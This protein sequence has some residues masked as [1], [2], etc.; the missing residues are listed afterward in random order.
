MAIKVKFITEG[1]DAVESG[2]KKVAGALGDVAKIAG[3]FVLAQG[4]MKAPAVL[5]DLASSSRDLE[6]QM[7]KASVVF[8]D[9]IGVVEDWADA[10][11]KS[12]GLT[13]RQA[14]NL[15]AGMAD[16]LVPMGM[17]REAAAKMSTETLNLSGAL[18]EWSGGQKSA[19][20]VAQILQSAY[21]GE[22]DGLKGLGIA[23]SA[24]D[25][26]ARLAAKGQDELTGAAQQQA[27]ALAI[28]E[29]IMEKSTDAQTAFANGA[30]SAARK[31]AEMNATVSQ[32]KEDLAMAMGPAVAFVTTK[33]AELVPVVIEGARVF[34]EEMQPKVMA[35]VDAAVPVLQAIGKV[36]A[37]E[38]AKFR[39]YYESDIKPALDNIIAGVSAVIA[40][41]VDH[42]PEIWRVVGP[43]MDMIQT[44]IETVVGVIRE[45]FQILIDLISGDFSGAWKNLQELIALIWNDI[46][47]IIS[48]TIEAVLELI[49]GLGPLMLEALGNMSELLVEA[50][51]DI[52]RGLIRGIGAMKDEALGAIG[53]VAS[54]VK[55]KAL[56]AFKINS[57]SKVFEDIGEGVVEGLV[58]G[59]DGK[60]ADAVR[61]VE[62][63]IKAAIAAGAVDEDA[64]SASGYWKMGTSTN[65][66]GAGVEWVD[67]SS[68]GANGAADALA[69]VGGGNGV[70]G[71]AG[72]GWAYV[73]NG[74]GGY[75]LMKFP[76]TDGQTYY[77]FDSTGAW[78]S[79]VFHTEK[80]AASTTP[81]SDGGAA[82]QDAPGTGKS[83]GV[84]N[85]GSAAQTKAAQEQAAREEEKRWRDKMLALQLELV[86]LVKQGQ[87]TPFGSG[88]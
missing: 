12:M 84:S 82:V 22:T 67:T 3:G 5:M 88:V 50:G 68:G 53:D 37:E 10:N 34:A 25:V 77:Y 16:L 69:T 27:Q 13:S 4:L 42:W 80:P 11:A 41:I 8:G 36:V 1:V 61:S 54:G 44:H 47:S 26:Q 35:F 20:E 2:A 60:A 56:G 63:M 17:S 43:I 32:A 23:I 73:A 85:Q 46:K 87:R 49:K 58:L 28:Q 65:G 75:K 40:F 59:I 15:A 52:I 29:L 79:G 14:T 18:A 6:L 9:Q 83:V 24:A 74:A 81:K 38:F 19:T 62:E 45:I 21:L 71:S 70:P 51:K 48:N 78:K 31:Q 72:S 57:P 64:Q 39:A 7:K 86:N 66:G 30:D 55:D 33:L 76:L